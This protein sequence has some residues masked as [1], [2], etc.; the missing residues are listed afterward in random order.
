[1][2]QCHM[3]EG[4]ASSSIK[5]GAWNCYGALILPGVT[6]G[7]ETI[8]GA[9]AVVTKDVQPGER[10]GGN[11]VEVIGF[12]KNENWRQLIANNKYRLKFKR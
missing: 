8:V 1:M 2:N 11:P 6:M 7:E 9:G 3:M 4:I 5:E 10:V 12:R